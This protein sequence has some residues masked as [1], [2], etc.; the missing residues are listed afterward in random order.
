MQELKHKKSSLRRRQEEAEE[1]QASIRR[2]REH[3]L[4][5]LQRQVAESDQAL[6]EE[7]RKARAI[8]QEISTLRGRLTHAVKEHAQWENDQRVA[9]D[10]EAQELLIE[11]R[12]LRS[13]NPSLAAAYAAEKAAG[14]LR[15]TQVGSSS[16]STATDKKLER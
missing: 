13:E 6:E 15:L 5:D 16:D 1:A 12:R 4:A 3:I 9:A 10:Q 11:L 2:E 8:E 7:R 14:T